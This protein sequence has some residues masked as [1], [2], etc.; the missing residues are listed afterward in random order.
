[1]YIFGH[2]DFNGTYNLEGSGT[3][4]KYRYT[5]HLSYL[6]ENKECQRGGGSFSWLS[7]AIKAT[8][9]LLKEENINKI[10]IPILLFQAGKDTFVVNEAH[11]KFRTLAKNCTVVFIDEGKH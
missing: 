5:N 4:D 3:S 7:K 8:R 11:N 10:D 6:K 9:K 2:K 1:E